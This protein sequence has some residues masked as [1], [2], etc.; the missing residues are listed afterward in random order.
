MIFWYIEKYF[1]Q[2][3]VIN[4]AAAAYEVE[5]T[6]LHPTRLNNNCKSN[7]FYEY[8]NMLFKLNK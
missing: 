8:W 7:I 1:V 5:I 6:R 3:C 2:S 4:L